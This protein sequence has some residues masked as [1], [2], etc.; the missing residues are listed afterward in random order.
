MEL[1]SEW[2][3]LETPGWHLLFNC[4][5]LIGVVDVSLMAAM[6]NQSFVRYCLRVTQMDV[7]LRDSVCIT[8]GGPPGLVSG[9]RLLPCVSR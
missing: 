1:V 7:L 4:S 3:G 5:P 2:K 6:G 8:L 9:G